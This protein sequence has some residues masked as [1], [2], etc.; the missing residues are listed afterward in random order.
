[1]TARG[2]ELRPILKTL[3]D[4]GEQYTRP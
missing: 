3:R 4:W 2:R 1:V